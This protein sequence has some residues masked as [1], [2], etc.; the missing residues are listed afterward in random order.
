MLSEYVLM[1]LGL[2]NLSL[3]KG[4]LKGGKRGRIVKKT[5]VGPC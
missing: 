1:L 5:V 2:T 4:F 3:N